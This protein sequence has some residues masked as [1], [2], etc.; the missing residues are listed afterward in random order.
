V[1]GNALYTVSAA[2]NLPRRADGDG[3][4]SIR[5]RWMESDGCR[6]TI[7]GGAPSLDFETSPELRQ[8]KSRVS[9]PRAA[10]VLQ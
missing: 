6:G 5:V 8:A 4:L 2:A 3:G 9:C 10:P 1:E 7:L